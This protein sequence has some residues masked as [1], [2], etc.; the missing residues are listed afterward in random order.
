[1]MQALTYI[2]LILLAYQYPPAQ[3]SNQVCPIAR[4]QALHG[5][6]LFKKQ[7]EY[8]C[9]GQSDTYIIRPAPEKGLGVFAGRDLEL[10]TVI[11]REAPV[12][13]IRPPEYVKGTGYPMAA[14]SQ[15][16]RADF[17]HISAEEQNTVMSLAYHGT[18]AEGSSSDP[19]GMI[20]KTNAYKSGDEIGLFPKIARINHSCRPNTSYVWHAKSDTRIMY[21]N[22][23][24]RKGEEILD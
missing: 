4:P 5:A 1:M 8:T 23:K 6:E 2:V 22:R 15:L 7:T 14:I 3:A 21:A 12:L 17:E 20:F 13:K 16:L 19:L 9:H 10:G 24:I 18:A 11:M